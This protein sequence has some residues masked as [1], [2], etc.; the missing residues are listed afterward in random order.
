MGYGRTYR[1]SYKFKHRDGR[2]EEWA[3]DSKLK[4]ETINIKKKT[5]DTA[6]G[7][8]NYQRVENPTDSQ[9]REQW[10]ENVCKLGENE[11]TL[12]LELL[13]QFVGDYLYTWDGNWGEYNPY[14]MV[15]KQQKTTYPRRKWRPRGITS[16]R[17]RNAFLFRMDR[18]AEAIE[19]VTEA[20]TRLGDYED[21]V[22][23]EEHLSS[24]I[25]WTK[26]NQR[27]PQYQ[28]DE[29][30]TDIRNLIAKSLM[31]NFKQGRDDPFR[32]LGSFKWLDYVAVLDHDTIMTEKEWKEIDYVAVLD[33]DTIMT[34]KEW[35]DSDYL[36]VGRGWAKEKI[37][38]DELH[39]KITQEMKDEYRKS[40]TE[41]YQRYVELSK[42]WIEAWRPYMKNAVMDQRWLN[43]S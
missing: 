41:A 39:P 20:Q 23:Y 36:N 35:K 24:I 4:F 34:E 19:I 18:I 12:L 25:T 32:D 21:N 28:H 5:I 27:L 15:A 1:E 38:L 7:N 22:K 43:F 31:N 10:I 40:V 30:V 16:T 17:A 2:S 14:L 9:I 13:P 33:H 3:E 26:D 11:I 29:S 42:I 8:E 37:H 6:F